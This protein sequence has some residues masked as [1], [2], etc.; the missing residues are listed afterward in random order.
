MWEL[1]LDAPWEYHWMLLGS[2][3]E[4]GW[5]LSLNAPLRV[6]LKMDGGLP[7]DAPWEYH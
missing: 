1:P 2:I 4:D 6:S 7:L 3:I 5:G